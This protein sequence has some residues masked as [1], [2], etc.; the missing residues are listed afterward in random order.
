MGSLHSSCN[1]FT[2]ALPF[3][4]LVSIC[5][6]GS[7]SGTYTFNGIGLG[8]GK[9]TTPFTADVVFTTDSVSGTGK[10]ENGE[11]RFAGG[12]TKFQKIYLKP[13][14]DVISYEVL[15]KTATEVTGT[16]SFKS[17]STAA[18]KEKNPFLGLFAPSTTNGSGTFQMKCNSNC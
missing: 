17:C 7:W 13:F 15:K 3:L 16:Y 5:S 9:T 12:A 18:Y 11:F 6:A 10:D 8:I 1:M 14:C 4:A 2:K